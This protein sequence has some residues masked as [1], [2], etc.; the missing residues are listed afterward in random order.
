MIYVTK[1]AKTKWLRKPRPG[2]MPAGLASAN[3]G[4]PL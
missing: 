3:G 1:L 2:M 4:K